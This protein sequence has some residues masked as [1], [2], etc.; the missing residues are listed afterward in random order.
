M[1]YNHNNILSFIPCNRLK[2]RI[3]KVKDEKCMHKGT[4]TANGKTYDY[5]GSITLLFKKRIANHEYNFRNATLKNSTSLSKIIWHMKGKEMTYNINWDVIHRGKA[6]R[7]V[8]RSGLPCFEELFQIL[9]SRY[10]LFLSL[11][12]SVN[13]VTLT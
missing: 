13:I 6:Y 2:K 12:D 1:Y 5:V 7:I 10:N 4:I 11:S 9:K 3:C 8:N